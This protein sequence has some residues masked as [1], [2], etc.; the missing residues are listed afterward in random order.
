MAQDHTRVVVRM[1]SELVAALDRLGRE[2]RLR[3][4]ELIRESV[5]R[6]LADHDRE[7]LRSQLIEGY[8]AWSAV[9]AVLGEEEWSPDALPRE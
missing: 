1:P 6:Y 2:R 4:S 9:Y 8:Q 7:T 3:R 5:E